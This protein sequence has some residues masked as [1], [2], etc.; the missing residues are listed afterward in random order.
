M[1]AYIISAGNISPQHSMDLENFFKWRVETSN[2][3]FNALE[4]DYS[5]FVDSKMIRRM[6]R[7]VKMG[8][9]ASSTCLRNAGV[10]M[11][12]AILTATAYGCLEDSASF[13]RK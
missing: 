7:I 9:A 6:S 12:A 4:P 5:T 8:V 10:D 2:D 3:F 13:L 11:P 1:S